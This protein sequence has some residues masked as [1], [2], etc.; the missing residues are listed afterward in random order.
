MNSNAPLDEVISQTPSFPNQAESMSD[1]DLVISNGIPPSVAVPAIDGQG[2]DKAAADSAITSAMLTPVSSPAASATV[3]VGEAFNQSPV[4]GTMVPPLSDVTYN[5]STG[6]DTATVPGVVGETEARAETAITDA[7]FVAAATSKTNT[8]VAIGIVIDQSPAG[9]DTAALGSTVDLSVSSG[10]LVP[11]VVGLTEADAQ[12][13]ILADGLILGET[14]TAR[15][16]FVAKGDVISQ[17]PAGNTDAEPGSAVNLVV[18]TGAFSNGASNGNAIDPWSLLLL[19]A[20]PLLRR[21]R[22]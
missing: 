12:M 4:A 3:T 14:K 5:I 18:S 2:Y 8:S 9:G 19:M 20:V 7:G 11:S 1:V 22:R 16:V 17:S 10:A 13:Q 6:P 21:R 15:D